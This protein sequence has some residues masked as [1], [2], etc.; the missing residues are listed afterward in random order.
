MGLLAGF[1]AN[2]LAILAL[3][4]RMLG[5]SGVLTS[6]IGM[7]MGLFLCHWSYL[8]ARTGGSFCYIVVMLTVFSLMSIGFGESA[9]IHLFGYVFGMLLGVGLYPKN[10]ESDLN[11]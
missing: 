1:C 3:E 11:S 6:Y 2:C 10:M 7:I 4:G 5:F 9:L 8:R